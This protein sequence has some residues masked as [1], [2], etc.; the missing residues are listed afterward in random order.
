MEKL[1]PVHVRI[2]EK[3]AHHLDLIGSSWGLDRSGLIRVAVARLI[4]AEEARVAAVKSVSL[5]EAQNV[6]T[7]KP[8]K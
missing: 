7:G 8:H 3:H 5:A 1:I 6:R 4:E 2:P